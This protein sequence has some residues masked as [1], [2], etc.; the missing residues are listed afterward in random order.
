MGVRV[1]RGRARRARIAAWRAAADPAVS[2][3]RR[4]RRAARAR[5]CRMVNETDI[6]ELE[7]KSKRFNLSVKKKEA[8][9]AEQ[10]VQVCARG[11]VLTGRDA[12]LTGPR[13]GGRG[14]ALAATAV[15]G[16]RQSGGGGGG[17]RAP[18]RG[19]PALLAGSRRQE[20]GPVQQ[21]Q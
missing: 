19:W 5:P 17:A 20:R 13:A 6:V 16:A 1:R 21:N 18:R 9:K 8:L 14:R 7:L 4:P 11:R 12:P 3:A 2:P 10:P 15:A